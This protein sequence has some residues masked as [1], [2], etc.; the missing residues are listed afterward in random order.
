MALLPTTVET[1]VGKCKV[2]HVMK[3]IVIDGKV[4]QNLFHGVH[5]S[6]RLSI[7]VQKIV[8][9]DKWLETLNEAC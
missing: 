4:C 8:S 5:P 9:K 3:L 1:H 2:N 6:Y 7:A